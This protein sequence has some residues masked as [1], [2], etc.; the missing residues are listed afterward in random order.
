MAGSALLELRQLAQYGPAAAGHKFAF[1]GPRQAGQGR[2]RPTGLGAGWIPLLPGWSWGRLGLNHGPDNELS[3]FD[4][5][6]S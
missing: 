2:R 5:H 3:D 1:L 4:G 6:Q